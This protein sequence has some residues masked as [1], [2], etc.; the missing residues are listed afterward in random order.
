MYIKK[1][2]SVERFAGSMLLFFDLS[3]NKINIETI[4]FI[5]IL[6]LN[7]KFLKFLKGS[8]NLRYCF[9]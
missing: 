9:V 4:I 1:R 7:E 6:L 2:C 8:D 3:K 5:V